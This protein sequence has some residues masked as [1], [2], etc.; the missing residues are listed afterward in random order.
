M[1]RLLLLAPMLALALG[2]S[3]CSTTATAPSPA[4][5]AMRL[6]TS[7]LQAESLVATGRA[8]G[9]PPVS[10]SVDAI[11]VADGLVGLRR[12]VLAARLTMPPGTTPM[13]PAQ[14]AYDALQAQNQAA[15][16]TVASTS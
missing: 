3:A 10:G 4:E 8:A 2:A 1:M 6:E 14:A 15:L 9:L 12:A 5:L 7:A 11:R 16:R 13:T